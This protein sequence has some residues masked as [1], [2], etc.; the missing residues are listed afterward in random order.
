MPDKMFG[1]KTL[2]TLEEDITSLH[3]FFTARLYVDKLSCTSRMPRTFSH[4]QVLL[5]VLYNYEN[6]KGQSH[7]FSLIQATVATLFQ[8]LKCPVHVPVEIQ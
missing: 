8:P 3:Q 5:Y 4:F 1:I 7:N 6:T 2:Y